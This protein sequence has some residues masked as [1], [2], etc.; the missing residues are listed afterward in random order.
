MKLQAQIP[1]K[2]S[3]QVPNQSGSQLPGL[4]Q[5]NGNA[6]PQ[7]PN[8]GV[9]PTMDP[10]FLR[11]RSFTLEKIYNILLQRYQHPVTEAH[12][13]KVKDIAKRLEEG[14][15]KTAISK[16]D[17]MNLDT[18]ESRLSN[19]FR[20]SSMNNHNQQHPQLVT[21]SPIGTM[22]PTPGMS[23][24][25]NSTLI[26]AS[27]VDASMI[28]ASGCNS[29]ASSSVNSVSM[30]PAG[31]ML[32]SSLNRSDG[33]SNGYQQSSTNL[34]I[35]SGGNMSSVGVQRVTSQ[36]I[37]TPGFS[38][39]NNH[40]YTN[41][42]PSTNSSSFSGV[43]S[44]LL[45]QSQSQRHQK[46]QD[47]DHNNHALQNLGSQMD[48]GMRSGLLQ[49]SFAYPNGSINNGL[50]LIGNNIQLA[51]GPG[52][53]DYASTYTNSPK[54]LQQHFDQNQ[55]PAVQGDGYG[56]INVDTFTSGSF[57]ASATSSGSMMNT[58]NM[59]AVKFPSIPIT[60]SLISGHSNLHSMHQTSHQK[61]QAIN[62]L[63]NLKFQS[64]LTSRD[65][66]VH[67]QQQ[68]QQR[69][70]QCHQSEWDAP[71]QCQLK[72]QGQQP[73][74]LVNSDAF[75]QSQLS[76]NLDNRVK[77][78]PGVEPHK[79]VHNSQLS[80]QFHVSEMQNQLQQISS[81]DCSKVLNIFHSPLVST[82][83]PHQHLKFHNKYCTH[84]NWLQ[85]LKTILFLFQL[86]HNRN[87]YL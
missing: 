36:M 7:M 13:R 46:L 55:Q 59:N 24:V 49:N 79:E 40:S 81:K 75:S 80:E 52:T 65:G 8:L 12:R 69:P 86:G 41:T 29:I 3:G 14:M 18:L 66:H 6:L 15:L 17:Y 82:T 72:L 61:S 76:S 28:A 64:S 58:Q 38:V 20:L 56:L 10:E 63:K 74:H 85:I 25:T 21:S 16:E 4:V 39:C 60:S 1:E 43:D 11:A 48:G 34:S 84:I 32:G 5:M 53:D 71:Q 67:T 27:S 45:S 73:Q 87:P 68:Y 54:H 26:T 44:T 37:P 78:E 31:G 42:G 19:F 35:G 2:I 30:L 23:H 50:G 57:Y 70:Q 83:H 51:N 47:S 77:S 9:F 33:L 22:I 62:S